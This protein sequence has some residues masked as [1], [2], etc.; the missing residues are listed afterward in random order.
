MSPVKDFF[1]FSY[2]NIWLLCIVA[3]LLSISCILTI[4]WTFQKVKR[5]IL[6]IFLICS[7]SLLLFT[8]SQ[9]T[10]INIADYH[11][12]LIPARTKT[13][14]FINADCGTRDEINNSAQDSHISKIG[15]DHNE[16]KEELQT[17]QKWIPFCN[18]DFV[19]EWKC[20][21]GR[22]QCMLERGPASCYIEF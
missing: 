4:L 14:C 3:I 5:R 11:N 17:D 12:G 18:F 2:T 6:L 15:C 19:V 10:A 7:T 21:N 9:P 1:P 8:Y 20:T 22:C 13:E 16:Y